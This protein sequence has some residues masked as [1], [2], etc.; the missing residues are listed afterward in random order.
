MAF[1]GWQFA[2]SVCRL[3]PCS[4]SFVGAP[5]CCQV[6]GFKLKNRYIIQDNVVT[7]LPAAELRKA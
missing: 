5:A 6:L 2:R 4:A 3:P 7:V 1:M